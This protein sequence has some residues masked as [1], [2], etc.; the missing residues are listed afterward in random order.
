[1]CERD[2]TLC[3]VLE[4]EQYRTKVSVIYDRT[5]AFLPAAHG[6]TTLEPQ[7]TLA[8]RNVCANLRRSVGLGR[9]LHGQFGRGLH[10]VG[11]DLVDEL[12]VYLDGAPVQVE[13]RS[14]SIRADCEPI[15]Y[16]HGSIVFIVLVA[17]TAAVLLAIFM[18]RD[19]WQ[20]RHS[21]K[22]HGF[23]PWLA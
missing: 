8:S 19:G 4:K 13:A 9:R 22:L 15:R 21:I 17:T 5:V 18:A 14:D 16:V 1:M 7:L 6:D 23:V 3:V 10:A 2:V 20:R 12:P 11:L